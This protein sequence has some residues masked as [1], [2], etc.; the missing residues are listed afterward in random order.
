MIMTVTPWTQSQADVRFQ[1]LVGVSLLAGVLV[2][3]A[4]SLV[5]LPNVA[6]AVKEAKPRL[7]E[8]IL[9]PPEPIQEVVVK[10]PKPIK[11]P[12]PKPEPKVEP[13]LE[14]PK[15]VIVA[16]VKQTVKQ[17]QE[18]AKLSGLLAFKDQL[19]AMRDQ[20]DTT[21]LD[22]GALSQ[23]IGEAVQ[24]ERSV[25]TSNTPAGK[26]ASVNT[27]QLS[28]TTGG[29]ALA[30]RETTIVEVL[31]DSTEATGAVRLVR[32][33]L[34]NVRSI[35]EIRRV[36]DANKGAIFSIYNRALRK[37]PS[38][39]GKVVLE[40]V[41]EPDGTVSA[42]DVL[43]SEL[44]NQELVAR[45]KRRVQLFDFGEKNVAVTRISYPVHFLPT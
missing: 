3:V 11:K 25:I 44:A 45:V 6:E 31:E 8:I 23:G 19:S 13:K 26:K 22:T 29:I 41:I 24:L 9:P 38:L 2:S 36:F 34:S 5:P 39:L 15:E 42:C 35:E 30:A 1:K 17:A 32:P 16:E 7:V 27:G 18:K 43:T 21:Q 14:P 10:I 40:L 4:V 20:A 12:E 37:D 28:K 33:D